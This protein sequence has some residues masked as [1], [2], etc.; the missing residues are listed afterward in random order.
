[1]QALLCRMK[2]TQLADSIFTVEDFLTRPEYL[3]N[4][5]LSESRL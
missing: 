4:L 2:F 5:V 1:M 3:E